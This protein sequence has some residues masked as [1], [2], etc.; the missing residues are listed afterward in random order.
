MT[1]TIKKILMTALVGLTISACGA[2]QETNNDNKEENNTPT[3]EAS[4]EIDAAKWSELFTRNFRSVDPFGNYT[5]TVKNGGKL[6]YGSDYT[7]DMIVKVDNG[8]IYVTGYFDFYYEFKEN[9]YNETTGIYD[10]VKMYQQGM[11]DGVKY[12]EYAGEGSAKGADVVGWGTPCFTVKKL[13]YK[14]FTFDKEEK[15][16]KCP[17]FKSTTPWL[18]NQDVEKTIENMKI[19]IMN[20]KVQYF[21]YD[22]KDYNIHIT[23]MFSSYGETTVT[24]PE[25]LPTE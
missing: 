7:D 24:T 17:S 23:S 16:Y 3:S 20:E 18:P 5:I 8:K 19:K 9:K 21:D 22:S 11:Q 4:F 15:V 1:G 13:M 10:K 2:K 25:G 12:W 6:F 14:D